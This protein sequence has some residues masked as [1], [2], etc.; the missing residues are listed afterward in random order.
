M[1]IVRKRL[2]VY[3]IMILSLIMLIRL[4]KDIVRLKTAD[5]RLLA[6]QEELALAQKEQEEL[7]QKLSAIN[8]NDWWEKQVRDVLKMARS[9][10]IVVVVPEAVIKTKPPAGQLSQGEEPGIDSMPNWKKWLVAFNF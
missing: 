8:E 2:L 5:Q 4:T 9:E 1:S 6:A 7:K 3:V 10:E